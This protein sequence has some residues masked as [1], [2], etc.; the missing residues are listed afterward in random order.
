MYLSERNGLDRDGICEITQGEVKVYR[1]CCVHC[2]IIVCISSST[3]FAPRPLR[4]PWGGTLGH[5]LEH[6]L[7][8]ILRL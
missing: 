6:V 8:E 1:V 7:L 3:K 2:M 5:G 4:V